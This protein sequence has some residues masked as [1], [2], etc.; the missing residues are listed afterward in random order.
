VNSDELKYAVMRYWRFRRRALYIATE[1]GAYTHNIKDILLICGKNIIEVECKTSPSDFAADF[2]K[3]KHSY[4]AIPAEFYNTPNLFYFAIPRDLRVDESLL[5][6]YPAYG[7]I[8][9]GPGGGV[10]DNYD[11]EMVR[12]ARHIMTPYIQKDRVKRA[13][14]A[15]FK[16][17]SSE[18]INVRRRMLESTAIAKA[19]GYDHA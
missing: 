12:K 13:K 19:K 7:L 15:I 9:V 14:D 11:V 16:R 10:N 2:K 5:D 8:R 18:I 4:Y 6:M 3:P 1:V 17:M